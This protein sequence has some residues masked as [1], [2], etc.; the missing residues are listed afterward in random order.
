MTRKVTVHL[1]EEAA[2]LLR[3]WAG[4]P[5]KMGDF[6]TKLIQAEAARRMAATDL[7]VEVARLRRDMAVLEERVSALEARS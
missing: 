3:E 7:P 5:R 2:D 4:T 1:D 6:L